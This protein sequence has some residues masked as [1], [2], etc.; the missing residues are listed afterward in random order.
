MSWDNGNHEYLYDGYKM[1]DSLNFQILEPAFD[2][3]A[4]SVDSTIA[5]PPDVLPDKIL[6]AF[7]DRSRLF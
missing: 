5:R 3:F 7:L 6:L 4:D 1:E 2:T